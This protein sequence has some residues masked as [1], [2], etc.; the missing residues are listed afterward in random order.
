M[1]K[2]QVQDRER[3]ATEALME[4]NRAAKE[5]EEVAQRF[6]AEKTRLER[7]LEA[8]SQQLV[9]VGARKDA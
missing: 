1:L 6:L 2:G 7:R 9:E 5:R 8:L 4:K 3:T